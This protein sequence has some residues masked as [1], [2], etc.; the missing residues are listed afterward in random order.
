MTQPSAD[1]GF[2]TENSLPNCSI[3]KVIL[4]HV[5]IH[6]ILSFDLRVIPIVKLKVLESSLWS[7][8]ILQARV[9]FSHYLNY[10]MEMGLPP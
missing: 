6:S 5:P 3:I 2:P 7:Y 8:L 1:C 4:D 10:L 9:H